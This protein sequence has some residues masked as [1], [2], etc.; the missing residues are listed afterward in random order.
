[1]P[2]PSV[3]EAYFAADKTRYEVPE[4]RTITWVE[5]SPDAVAQSIEIPE[6]ELRAAYDEQ[7]E[8]L[9][10]PERREVQQILLDDEEAAKAA[11][12]R[13]AG[14]EDFAAVAHDA[15]GADAATL[16]LGKIGRAHVGTPGTNAHI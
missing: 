9:A 14:G 13:I 5:I 15:T 3:L 10:T 8:Y 11:R 6:E 12:A 1:M 4:Y 7:A 2:E 16:D